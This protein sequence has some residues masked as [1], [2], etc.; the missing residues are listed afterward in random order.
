MSQERIQ[1]TYE[2]VEVG[3]QLGPVEYELTEEE[4][5]SY[6]ERVQDSGEAL[7]SPDG[8]RAAP[9]EITSGDYTKVLATK[10]SA[11]DVIHTRASHQFKKA[12]T[13]PVKLTASGTIIDKYIRRGREYL[14]IET[15][16]R[17]ESGDEVVRSRNTW[18]INASVRHPE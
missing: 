16:T 1:A 12:I 4:M 7:E 6:L 2:T 11:Y 13:P 15:V 9:P 5:A 14:V 17:D 3:E 10:Y 18:L 8:K